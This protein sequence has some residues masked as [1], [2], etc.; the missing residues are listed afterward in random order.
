[1]KLRRFSPGFF[2]TF[3]IILISLIFIAA[4]SFSA[5]IKLSDIKHLNLPI[6]FIETENGKKIKSKTEYR[7]ASYRLEAG[8][9]LLEG[10]CKIR[11]RG[12]TTWRTRELYKKPFLLKLSTPE[13]LLGMKKNEK[14][15]LMANTADKTSLR[16][17]YAEYL[18]KNI[19]SNQP[20]TPSSRFTILY[21]NGR[22]EGLYA[23]TEKVEMTE[24]RIT[25]PSDESFLAEVNS[26]MNKEWNFRSK[27]GVPFSIRKEIEDDLSDNDKINDKSNGENTN[28]ISTAEETYKKYQNIIQNI[29]NII[30][31]DNFTDKNNGYRKYLDIDSFVDWY[32]IN[33]F[34]KNTDA[35]FQSSCYL[36]YNEKKDKLF[37]GP[38]WDFD[39]SCG[40]TSWNNC[41]Y[42]EGEFIN[43][44]SWYKRL[45]ED[46]FFKESVHNRFLLKTNELD[47][48]F[49]WIQDQ[50]D[51]LYPSVKINDA[52]WK[53]IGHRQWPHAPGW[54]GRKTY[55]AEVDYMI[56][57]L[58][59]RKTWLENEYKKN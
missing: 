3:F 34:T 4:A 22:F 55:Q 1:M 12:N 14:W 33:E 43:T 48:S 31:S 56:D 59:K 16:N 57:F 29:E 41:Q 47:N 9:S 36:Y 35:A 46:N 49:K 44:N 26:H 38:I 13:S 24:G 5:Q 54:K 8:N 50:A 40:N 53:N 18:A 28:Q 37:M 42:P 15:V 39:L 27:H 2:I 19:F 17:Y 6:L 23:I 20:W 11:G 51:F 25:P 21:I 45:F 30:F 10:K 7:K 58:K 32:L 52:V